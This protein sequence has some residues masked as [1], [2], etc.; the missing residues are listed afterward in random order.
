MV[1]RQDVTVR[2]VSGSDLERWIEPLARLRTAVFR[3]FPYLYV[4]NA[5]YEARYLGRYVESPNAVIVLALHGEEV[6]GASTAMP[7]ADEMDEVKAPFLAEGYRPEDV[8][9]LGES[10]LLPDY[11]GLGLGV[12]FFEEREGHA[13]RLGGFRYA[14]F[15]AVDR[16]HDHPRRPADYVPLDRFWRKR[17]YERHPEL[18]THIAWQDLDENGESDKPMTFW[19]KR[20]D[21]AA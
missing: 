15:C 11:R 6:V 1:W 4:G 5:D 19:V 20:L 18:H 9:Y 17:G 13:H 3:E 2:P 7:M 21:G 14:T 12:R 8:F 10:V 16:P